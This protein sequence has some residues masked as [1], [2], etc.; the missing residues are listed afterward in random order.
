MAIID[1]ILDLE[2]KQKS[3]FA[4]KGKYAQCLQTP[5]TIPSKGA[6]ADLTKLRK[7]DDESDEI[8]FIPREKDYAFTVDVWSHKKGSVV[9]KGFKITAQRDLGDGIIE[10]ITKGESL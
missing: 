6:T 8:D 5:E 10:T 3:L 1:D 2:Q 7:P 4:A 9:T